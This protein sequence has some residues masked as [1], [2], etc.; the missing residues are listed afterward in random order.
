MLAYK[1][2][3]CLDSDG[4]YGKAE[5]L[6][7]EIIKKKRKRLKDDDPSMLSNMADLV[8]TYQNQGR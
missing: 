4:R 5:I 8:S 2:R 3:K 1:I 6:L 7:K